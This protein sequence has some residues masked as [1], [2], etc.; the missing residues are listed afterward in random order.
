VTVAFA[1]PL[2]AHYGTVSGWMSHAFIVVLVVAYLIAFGATVALAFAVATALSG[3]D[4]WVRRAAAAASGLPFAYV[5][6]RSIAGFVEIR[7]AIA[8]ESVDPLQR[9]RVLGEG[10]SDMMNCAAIGGLLLVPTALALA[11]MKYWPPHTDG[12]A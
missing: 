1:P 2:A 8:A 5:S 12:G 11:L 3:R 6:V 4:P 7:L 10:I 9:A